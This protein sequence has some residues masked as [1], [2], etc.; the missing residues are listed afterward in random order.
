MPRDY[1]HEIQ[2]TRR[3]GLGSMESWLRGL[4]KM[5]LPSEV[6]DTPLRFARVEQGRWLIDCPDC[7][8]ATLADLEDPRFFCPD[9]Q[10]AM[11]GGVWLRVMLPPNVAAIEHEL[12]KR[13][14]VNRNW[15]PGETVGALKADNAI[16]GVDQVKAPT[17]VTAFGRVV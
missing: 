8:G 7:N 10:N 12:L 6:L 15:T 9:C 16:H 4:L 3:H 13:P 11:S 1:I 14:I 17:P 5:R 2:T